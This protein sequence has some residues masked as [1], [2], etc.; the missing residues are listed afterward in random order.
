[1]S[2]P[3]FFFSFILSSFFRVLKV[4]KVFKDGK[5]Y[6]VCLKA[7]VEVEDVLH[8]QQTVDVAAVDVHIIVIGVL[9]AQDHHI[10]VGM[11]AHIFHQPEVIKLD[12]VDLPPVNLVKVADFA[13]GDKVSVH[14]DWCHRVAADAHNAAM[15]T[16]VG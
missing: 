1:M 5:D 14:D 9:A 15:R 2:L 3:F 6:K 12:D 7:G 11:A 8:E 10:G 16:H 4:F 13:H